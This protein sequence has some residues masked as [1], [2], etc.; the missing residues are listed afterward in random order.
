MFESDDY[1]Q[2]LSQIDFPELNASFPTKSEVP[3]K[4][5]EEPEKKENEQRVFK[6]VKT[7]QTN[8]KH[9]E[10][11]IK[12]TTKGKQIVLSNNFTENVTATLHDVS[13]KHTKRKIIN[14]Y[15]DHKS[16]RKFPGPAGL[17]S[18]NFE[19]K[20][21]DG[22]CHM[23]LLS[24]DIDYTQS[25][26][27][28]NVFETPLWKRLLEDT[29]SLKEINSINS[30]K[31]QALTGNLHRKKAQFVVALVE[32]VDRSAIDPLITLRDRTGNIKCTLHRDAW[33]AFSAYIVSEYCALVLCKP[34]VLTT[35]SAFKKHY[36]NITLS[37]ISV[38]YSSA[39]LNDDETLPD[40][41]QKICEEDY[42]II[43]T[44]KSENISPNKSMVDHVDFLDDL[45][46]VFSDDLF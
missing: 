16:K 11:N 8:N 4:K 30:I 43:Q 40:G 33:T 12:S 42:T 3:Q 15:F 34:T 14:S 10:T 38:I 5:V 44:D 31:D 36:L 26:L 7:V 25:Y 46:D 18:G 32:S 39:V 27:N 37:N 2:V 45:D 17:L 6:D 19:E 41:Y 9:I 13:P 22:V 24:Q 20:K 29:A 1:D 23:E 21:D 28:C 35:G